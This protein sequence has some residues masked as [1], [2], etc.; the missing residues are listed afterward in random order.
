MRFIIHTADG[1]EHV[2]AIIPSKSQD[3]TL[4]WVYLSA[5]EE[6][7]VWTV[8]AS[9]IEMNMECVFPAKKVERSGEC[10]VPGLEFISRVFYR[11]DV[12]VELK[13]Q[14]L[15]VNG[16]SLPTFPVAEFPAVFP[17]FEEVLCL[18][19][20]FVGYFR[21]L[22][23]SFPLNQTNL[24]IRGLLMREDGE[25][26]IRATATNTKTISQM[27]LAL[28]DGEVLR[29][30]FLAPDNLVR[31]LDRLSPVEFGLFEADDDFVGFQCQCSGILITVWHRRFDTPF[32]P[33]DSI[34]NDLVD[35]SRLVFSATV[36]RW[37]LA[38]ACNMSIWTVPLPSRPRASTQLRL[39]P[40]PYV[41]SWSQSKGRR[42][43]R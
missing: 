10:C 21:K 6:N 9:G 29:K 25:G 22:A 20:I 30:P 1:L 35:N 28:P 41:F 36:D 39:S 4:K 5:D 14:K 15:R 7:Q 33:V 27:V 13:G 43:Y 2:K 3:P 12:T 42:T 34:L 16:G 8:R 24:S 18:P 23:I 38:Q 26:R 37:K 11:R 19:A 40:S 17:E 32:A 31:T